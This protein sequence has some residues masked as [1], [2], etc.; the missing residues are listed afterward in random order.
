MKPLYVLGLLALSAAVWLAPARAELTGAQLPLVSADAPPPFIFPQRRDLNGYMLVLH[1]PQI[2]SWP[3]F[4][5]LEAFVAIELTPPGGTTPSIGTVSVTGATELDRDNR[6]VKIRDPKIGDVRFSSDA[7]TEYVA[8]VQ[9]MATRDELDVPLDLFLAQLADEVLASPPP[10]GFSTTPP[11]IHVASKPTL[12]LFVNGDPVLTSIS[13][14]GLELVANANWPVFKDPTGK[15][16]FYLLDRDLWLTSTKLDGGWEKATS[17]RPGFMKLAEDGEHAAVASAVPWRESALPMPKIIYATQP[18]ELIVTDGK[19]RLEAIAGA[20]GL[21]YVTN[22]DSPLFRLHKTWYFL[23]AG[24]WFTTTNLNKGPWT[25]TAELPAV[26]AQIPAEHERAAVR[27]SIP[28]TVEARMAALEALLPTRTEVALDAVPPVEVTY[29]GEPKFEPVTGTQVSRAVNSGYDIIAFE[30][31]YYLCYAGVWYQSRSAVGPWQVAASVPAEIYSIPPSSPAYQVTQVTVVESTSS[32]VVY[33]YPPSYSSSVYVVYGVPYYGTGWYYPPYI[34]SGYYYPYWGSYG[35][36]SWYNPATGGYGSR[37][38][39]YGPYGG[40]SYTQGY[41]PATGR[42]GYMETAWDGNEWASHGETYNPRTG[43]GTETSRYVNDKKNTSEMERT[44][45]RGDDWLKTDRKVDWDEGTA[46]VERKTSGGASSDVTREFGD[47]TM[48]SSGTI[49]TGDG[50]TATISGEATRGGGSST[51]TGEQGSID[52]TTK[53]QDER[54]ATTIE[55]SGGGQGISVSGEGPGRT[56]IGQS[57]SGDLYA[58]HNGNV[59]KKTDDGWQHYEDGGWQLAD[60]PDR[61]QG[62][63]GRASTTSEPRDYSRPSNGASGQ[64]ADYSKQLDQ[65]RTQAQQRDAG[66]RQFPSTDYSQ[67]NRDYSARQRGSQ[68]FQQRSGGY[69]GYQRGGGSFQRGGGGF[70]GGGGGRRR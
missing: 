32:S 41:N 31:T 42:Y 20:D 16:M 43:V 3:Q 26:F 68:Q 27:A 45:E 50:R 49:T 57:G 33:S 62:E 47:G 4:E 28:G 1:A 5:S 36:G 40:Y 53:R 13:G 54:S 35:H 23:V 48:S 55:A 8:M 60:T 52:T 51:I 59:Y 6:I 34:Y 7:P 70:G 19:A 46:E 66:A 2:R 63:G 67:L 21:E 14:T 30:G 61:G 38:V 39:W 25:Y 37:S 69:G 18:T 44:V 29:A 22:T 11:V 12:L 24:R 56:T 64:P 9:S 17:L 58:G 10:P 65:A 15:G